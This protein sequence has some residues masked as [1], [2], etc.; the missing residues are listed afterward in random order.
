VEHGNGSLAGA[1]F[2]AAAAVPA[3]FG[4]D[5]DGWF[6]LFRV[7]HHDIG[8]ADFDTQVAAGT[9]SGIKVDGLI[10]CWWIG[11]DIS[12]VGHF[13]IISLF[14]SGYASWYWR[15]FIVMELVV[16]LEGRG[17]G[18]FEVEVQG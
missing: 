16:F 14:I 18:W 7:G 5:D 15:L 13:I 1:L 17:I 10:R 4:I 11:Y 2:D 8:G 9:D 6:F 3:F 12:L